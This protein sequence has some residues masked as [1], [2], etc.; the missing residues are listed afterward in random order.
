KNLKNKPLK[1]HL[2]ETVGNNTWYHGVLNGKTVFI[3]S[4]YLNKKE[5]TKTSKLGH[6]RSQNVVIRKNITDTNGEKAGSNATHKVYYI[7]KKAK[8]GNQL[9]YLIGKSPTV[10]KDTLGRVKYKDMSTDDNIDIVQ[11]SMQIAV[12]G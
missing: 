3:H 7:K 10:S 12:Q 2:T 9:Y 11:N 6:L 8:L 1:V 5:E 4:S